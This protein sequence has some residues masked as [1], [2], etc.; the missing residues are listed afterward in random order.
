MSN[1]QARVLAEPEVIDS[2]T[3]VSTIVAD[4]DVLNVK[5]V[6]AT[7]QMSSKPFDGMN[8]VVTTHRDGTT[9]AVKVVK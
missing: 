1:M 3:G 2:T 5:Y 6:N 9:K 8:I 7:G 4:T